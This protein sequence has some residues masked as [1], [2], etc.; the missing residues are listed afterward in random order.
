M[1]KAIST[2]FGG[3]ALLAGAASATIL[4]A[5]IGWGLW[6]IYDSGYDRATRECTAARDE[7]AL[8]RVTAIANTNA[9]IATEIQA[10]ADKVAAVTTKRAETNWQRSER[11]N[12]TI[13][14]DIANAKPGP[15]NAAD[16]PAL[17]S[18]F[19]WVHGEVRAS[20][21]G[22]LRAPNGQPDAD[23]QATVPAAAP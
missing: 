5:L 7:A 18:A 1:W 15:C 12:N 4:L 8:A 23:Y 22:A 20:R 17:Y 16:I 19:E 9:I 14:K 13:F 10:D 2:F 11:I 3:H 21:G 6:A